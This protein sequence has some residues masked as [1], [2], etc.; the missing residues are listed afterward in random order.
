VGRRGKQNDQGEDC[1]YAGCGTRFPIGGLYWVSHGY[2][3]DS[4]RL[5]VATKKQIPRCARDDNFARFANLGSVAIFCERLVGGEKLPAKF[6][7]GGEDVPGSGVAEM[8]R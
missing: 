3:Q 5:L 4:V 2:S 7:A 8:D 1:S 6:R